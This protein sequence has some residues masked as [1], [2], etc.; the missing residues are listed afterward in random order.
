MDDPNGPL[1]AERR[2]FAALVAGDVTA[3]DQLLAD[4]LI[5]VDVMSGSETTKPMLLGA[6]G[7]GGLRFESIEPAEARARIYGATA[8]ING[9]TVMHLRF[10]ETAFSTRSRYTH[11]WVEQE[12]RWRMVSAQGTQIAEQPPGPPPQAESPA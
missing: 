8:V 6:L 11:V 3:L 4:D 5:L 1:A 7:T 12:G 2:Y 10:G 9:R